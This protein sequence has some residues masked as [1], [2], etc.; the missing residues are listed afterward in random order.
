MQHIYV[1]QFQWMPDPWTANPRP[2]NVWLPPMLSDLAALSDMR[3]T[4]RT[5]PPTPE[6]HA[7]FVYRRKL[8][9][10]EVSAND[11]AYLGDDPERLVRDSERDQWKAWA[12]SSVRPTGRTLLEVYWDLHTSM[13][14]PTYR[15]VGPWVQRPTRNL[16][17]S[18]TFPGFPQL[19]L[20][21]RLTSRNHPHWPM[22]LDRLRKVYEELYN[23]ARR[24]IG[25]R[26]EFAHR[27]AN[28]EG[29]KLF[30]VTDHALFIPPNL[31]IETPLRRETKRWDDFTEGSDTNLESHTATGSNSGWDWTLV[32]GTMVVEAGDDKAH[33]QND[34]TTYYRCS[35]NGTLSG[36][37]VAV[38]MEVDNGV[39]TSTE[40]NLWLRRD[41]A[42]AGS[43]DGY[44]ARFDQNVSMRRFDS[45]T[46]TVIG[47]Q[48]SAYTWSLPDT[49]RYTID[50]AGGH[51][52]LVNG[53]SE[54]TA[55]DDQHTANRYHGA[56]QTW[57]YTD[58]A[59]W[60]DYKA[61]DIRG[62]RRRVGIGAGHGTRR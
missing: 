37:A 36:D 56:Q 49:V 35:A 45:G 62:T 16:E 14:D 1:G 58:D 29:I 24:S 46:P 19:K 7:L 52:M 26:M 43:E 47:N 30:Q 33:S 38:E 9:A 41:T 39:A 60:E 11:L 28:D 59:T 23:E 5:T 8:T 21:D 54:L 25:T 34:N 55:T 51:E 15:G 44:G 3:G 20:V 12:N 13:A 57:S 61:E 10:Q 48:A 6:G 2:P 32:T 53:T 22:L 4:G 50:G 31:P 18:V 17:L 40:P 27:R 42:G